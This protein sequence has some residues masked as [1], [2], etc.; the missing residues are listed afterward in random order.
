MNRGLASV[1]LYVFLVVSLAQSAHIR[2]AQEVEPNDSPETANSVP[3]G[4]EYRGVL[5]SQNGIGADV[6]YVQI[7]V[8]FAGTIR[9]VSDSSTS[10]SVELYSETLDQIGDPVTILGEDRVEFAVAAGLYYLRIF[11][12]SGAAGATP[13]Y[14]FIVEF[15]PLPPGQPTLSVLEHDRSSLTLKITPGAEGASATTGFEVSCTIPSITPEGR[16]S[17]VFERFVLGEPS[18]T[19]ASQT[20]DSISS[21]VM[22]RAYRPSA[23]LGHIKVGDTLEFVTPQEIRLSAVVSQLTNTGLNNK[24]IKAQSNDGEW[25]VVVGNDGHY[26]A[27]LRSRTHGVFHAISSEIETRVFAS[28][29]GELAKNALRDDAIARDGAS[30][31]SAEQSG[32]ARVGRT[33]VISVGVQY[34]EEIRRKYDELALVDYIFEVANASYQNAGVDIVF[35]V[36]GVRHFEPHIS[37]ES[38]LF[39]LLDV[40]CG[41]DGICA[42]DGPSNPETRA[43]RDEIKADVM[44]QLV[45]FATDSATYGTA[46][47]MAYPVHDTSDRESMLRGTHNVTSFERPTGELCP[48]IVLAHEIGHNL[49]LTHD[50]ISMAAEGGEGYPTHSFGWGY[51]EPDLVGTIMAILPDEYRVLSLSTPEQSYQGYPLGIP[52]GQENE[53]DAALAVMK[54]MD[55][56]EAIYDNVSV[57]AYRV[58]AAA[59][60]GGDITPKRLSVEEGS[61]ADF[62]ATPNS[63]FIVAGMSGCNGTQ[64]GVRYTTG[65]IGAPCAIEAKFQQYRWQVTGSSETVTVSGLPANETFS[66]SAAAFNDVAEAYPYS[67]S[68][69]AMTIPPTR[70]AAPTVV[71]VETG[72][73]EIIFSLAANDNGG[74]I[75]LDYTATCEAGGVFA[76]VTSETNQLVLSGLQNDVEYLCRVSARNSVDVSEESP[77]PR[78][79]TPESAQKGLPIWLLYQASQ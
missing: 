32:S 77:V 65:P 42:P 72:D 17:R 52:Q 31:A 56:Y 70:P 8:E 43:W 47:G 11:E 46:C 67:A 33:V 36:V 9:L 55:D 24:L 75:I 23:N 58:E 28:A 1:W 18:D 41:N 2:A 20:Q 30:E 12:S 79:L 54:V 37:E 53:A 68:V 21:E 15:D 51:Q 69:T 78:A 19:S 35:D 73:G 25:I 29:K 48:D 61:T 60:L 59:L 34:D 10:V 14:R 22:G 5:W 66:C 57:P 7:S 13:Q 38:L 3:S 16:Q 39:T 50:R 44:V 6:D 76:T 62:V 64:D 74:S 27:S 71:R 4:S 49:G 26:F 40:M 63:D 45:R